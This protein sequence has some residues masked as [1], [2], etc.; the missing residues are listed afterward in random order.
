L[1]AAKALKELSILSIGPAA[2][3]GGVGCFSFG[4]FS[5]KINKWSY[6]VLRLG[7]FSNNE[8]GEKANKK[9][10]VFLSFF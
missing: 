10:A 2:G 8:G 9:S 4:C 5:L 1:Y 3:G 6:P 7:L